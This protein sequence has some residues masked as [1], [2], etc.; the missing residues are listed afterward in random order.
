MGH[1][2]TGQ[3]QPDRAGSSTPLTAPGARP[4][5]STICFITGLRR[6]DASF[7]HHQRRHC[8]TPQS[9]VRHRASAPSADAR[10]FRQRHQQRHRLGH[11]SRRLPAAAARPCCTPTTP[12]TWRRNYTTPARTSRAT[13][14]AGGE[15]DHAVVAGGKVYVGAQYALSVFGPAIFPRAP[16]ISPAGGAFTNSVTIT[17]SGRH[18][19]RLHY[20]T[21][22]MAHSHT[23]SCCTPAPST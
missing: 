12:P 17:L 20:T 13:I 15:D 1:Y 8:A 22:W 3:R 21:R 14:R 6:R 4:R 11:R 10:H 7:T 2:N 5:I 18:G 23:S 19:G 9:V 16:V